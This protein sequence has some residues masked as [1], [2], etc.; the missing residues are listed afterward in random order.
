MERYHSDV[1]DPQGNAIQGA[2]VTVFD[3]SG[4]R[5]TIYSDNGITE[6]LNPLSTNA[7]GEFSFFAVNGKYSLTVQAT[8]YPTQT[9][10]DVILG[11]T[12]RVFTLTASAELDPQLHA[13]AWIDVDSADAV[14]LTVPSTWPVGMDNACVIREI[15]AGSVELVAGVGVTLATPGPLTASDQNVVIAFVCV[16]SGV[17][18]VYGGDA[19]A[20]SVNVVDSASYSFNGGL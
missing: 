5:A 4:D 20:V 9:I 6:A 11:D 15:G 13:G 3:A 12:N 1:T 18:A 2:T 17:C 8:G 16:A 14:G 7:Q 19:E 10:T